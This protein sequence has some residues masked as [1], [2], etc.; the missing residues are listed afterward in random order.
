MSKTKAVDQLDALL[1][2]CEDMILGAADRDVPPTGGGDEPV[3]G[4][5]WDDRLPAEARRKPRPR[6]SP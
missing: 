2:G 5:M 1:L 3:T 4:L 6:E